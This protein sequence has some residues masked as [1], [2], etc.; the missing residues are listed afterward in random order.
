MTQ[1]A[2]M[3][4]TKGDYT[5]L[6]ILSANYDNAKGDKVAKGID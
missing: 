3:N 2:M 4:L 6:C 1:R 5:T